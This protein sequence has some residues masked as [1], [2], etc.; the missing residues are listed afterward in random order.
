[1]NWAK[2][3]ILCGRQLTTILT[4]WSSYSCV[5]PSSWVWAGPNDLLL[6]T[7]IWQKGQDVTSEIVRSLWHLSCLYSMFLWIFLDLLFSWSQAPCCETLRAEAHVTRISQRAPANSSWETKGLV[8]QT[9]RNWILPTAMRMSS[10]VDHSQW[11]QHLDRSLGRDPE[12]QSSVKPCVYLDFGPT[13]IWENKCS[14][15][16]PPSL[17]QFVM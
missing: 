3:R 15:F 8:Q 4:Y 14:C 9:T 10:E 7:R 11:G 6:T 17:G 12:P 13:E 5:I 1:M 16:R 2:F